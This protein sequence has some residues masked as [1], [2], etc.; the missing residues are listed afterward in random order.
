MS[1]QPATKGD[2][3]SS[4][5]GTTA[6]ATWTVPAAARFSRRALA[7]SSLRSVADPSLEATAVSAAA[8]SGSVRDAGAD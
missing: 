2:L 3:L 5:A 6:S 7:P 8:G 1:G 4:V